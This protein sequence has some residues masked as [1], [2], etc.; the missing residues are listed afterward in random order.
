MIFVDTSFLV[1]LFWDIDPNTKEALNLWSKVDPEK[2]VS[3]D[4]LKETLTVLSQRIGRDGAIAAYGKIVEELTVLPV[5]SDRYQSGLKLFLN[6]K[7]Q[8][9]IS[10][11][12]CISAAICRELR[13]KQ[14]L[15]FDNHFKSL[16]LKIIS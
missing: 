14:I 9:D 3:E 8:K 5:H 12:D 13:I 15:S 10:L 7:L 1:A 11:I 16:G 4:I 6:P 2:I